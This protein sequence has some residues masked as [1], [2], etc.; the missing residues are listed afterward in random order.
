M[1]A[2]YPSFL[3]VLDRDDR[4]AADDA[5]GVFRSARGRRRRRGPRCESAR[6]LPRLCAQVKEP[7]VSSRSATAPGTTVA[8]KARPAVPDV[9]LVR[10]AEEEVRRTRV[11]YSPGRFPFQKA[12]SKGGS[13][14]RFFRRDRE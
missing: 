3:H 8:V 12:L 6:A 11:T 5:V 1:S 2:P 4:R 7:S 13:P 9:E 10:V 14:W